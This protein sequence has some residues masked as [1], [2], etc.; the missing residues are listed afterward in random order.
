[1]E[2]NPHF[3]EQYENLQ[4]RDQSS[5]RISIPKPK[6]VYAFPVGESRSHNKNTIKAKKLTKSI[7]HVCNF[8]R[9]PS[10]EAEGHVSCQSHI[11]ILD[12]VLF[13]AASQ[14]SFSFLLSRSDSPCATLPI[15]TKTTHYTQLIP[16]PTKTEFTIHPGGEPNRPKRG[17]TDGISKKSKG[18]YN[19]FQKVHRVHRKG[20]KIPYMHPTTTKMILQLIEKFLCVF[21][22]ILQDCL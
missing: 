12:L 1:M 4:G 5:N 14:S 21:E 6:S 15:P 16:K 18:S 11:K 2:S 19:I 13:H 8:W 17:Q 9:A 3:I 7:F 20:R 22:S 10:I